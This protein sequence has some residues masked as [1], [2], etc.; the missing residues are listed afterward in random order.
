MD[1]ICPICDYPFRNEDEVVA[2]MVSKFRLIDS[3]VNFALEH[4][5]KCIEVVHA[6]CYDYED[7]SEEDE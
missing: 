1:K 6:E 4:P 5:T 3:S 2:I 7:D